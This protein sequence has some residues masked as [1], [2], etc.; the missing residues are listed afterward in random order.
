MKKK[1]LIILIII[2]IPLFVFIGYQIIKVLDYTSS[3]ASLEKYKFIDG[4]K[5]IKSL[6][7][8]NKNYIISKYYDTSSSWSSLNILLKNNDDYYI[9]KTIRKCDTLDDGSNLYIKNSEV[10][11]HCIGKENNIAK[12]SINKLITSKETLNFDFTNTPNISQMHMI[13]DS[14]DNEYIYLSSPF[15][16]DNTVLDKPKVKCSFKDQKCYYIK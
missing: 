11:I 10:Y 14:V 3:I 12:Y 2:L 16:V 9:L 4:E 5:V 15:K 6:N 1:L 8:D 7:Y 13:I